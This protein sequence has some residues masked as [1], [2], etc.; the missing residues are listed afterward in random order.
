V[1][2]LTHLLGCELTPVEKS[3]IGYGESRGMR[4]ERERIIKLLE[5]NNKLCTEKTVCLDADDGW[6]CNCKELMA[7]IKGEQK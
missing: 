4:A 5:H 3:L 7:L 1:T 2:E 6:L